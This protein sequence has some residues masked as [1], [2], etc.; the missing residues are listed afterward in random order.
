MPALPH[1][2]WSFITYFKPHEFAS[3]D[4]PRSY[5]FMDYGLVT[6]LDTMRHFLDRS[7]VINSGYRTPMHNT[8][9][10]GVDDS[11]HLLGFAVDVKCLTS[12]YRYALVFMAMNFG[13][14][15]IGVYPTFVHLGADPN[16]D[17]YIMFHKN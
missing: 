16:K 14:L 4:E 15:Q 9:V 10:C 17:K 8:K 2:F 3:P 11:S 12:D 1:N 7:M 5:R 13:I 6:C